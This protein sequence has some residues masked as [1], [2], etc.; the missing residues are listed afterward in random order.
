MGR[1]VGLT[2]RAFEAVAVGPGM[3][4][5]TETAAKANTKWIDFFIAI[6]VWKWKARSNTTS[7]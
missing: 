5:W 3:R 1:A 6:F 7:N 4:E 2:R